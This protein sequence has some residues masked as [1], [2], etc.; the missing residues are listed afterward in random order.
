MKHSI[1]ELVD[2]VYRYYPRGV[3]YDDPGRAQTVED[4]RLVE[5][6]IEAGTDCERWLDLQRRL[7]VQFPGM[8]TDVSVLLKLGT[9]DAGYAGSV[10]V[11]N[12]A[13]D[14]W[15]P[16]A[17]RV[18]VLVPYYIVYGARVVE[19]L[20]GVEPRKASR[21]RTPRFVSVYEHDTMYVVPSS[22]VKPELR[23][24]ARE[25]PD[26][27]RDLS[28]DL[29]SE[30]RPHASTIAQ[31]IEA[32]YGYEPI[33]P[34]IGELVVPDVTLSL[35]QGAIA[36]PAGEGA[37]LRG[38][39]EEAGEHAGAHV[40]VVVT[41]GVF[42]RERVDGRGVGAEH[43]GELGGGVGTQVEMNAEPGE[44]SLHDD[45]AVKGSREV[46]EAHAANCWRKRTSFSIR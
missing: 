18:S 31:E 45:Y 6:R 15:Y 33:P 4:R 24:P 1:E 17:Y 36:I 28:F 32:T 7:N 8:V 41:D 39:G 27:R 20:A 35:A 38:A 21:P 19:E 42:Q 22:L 13:G 34:E 30:E 40:G 5:A 23:G 44:G 10:H 11:P 12:A 26:R 9:H 16:L 25:V 37:A 43:I 2:V 29:S 46:K 3:S 14:D